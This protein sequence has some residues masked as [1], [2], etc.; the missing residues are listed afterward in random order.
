MSAA[1]FL[2]QIA[3]L[4]AFTCLVHALKPRVGKAPL[5]ML[6]GLYEAFLF[7]STKTKDPL[8][9][10][11]FFVEPR[12]IYL[13]FLGTLMST[14]VLVY[15]LEGTREARRVIIGIAVLYLTHG[16]LD[17][18]LDHH[19]ANPPPGRPVQTGADVFW[20]STH[21]RIASLTAMVCD[22][23]V[24]IIVYQFL[25][26]RAPRLPLAVPLFLGI[27]AAM[28]T[29]AA[30][31]KLVRH[32]SLS[33]SIF[34]VGAKVQAGMA[35]GLPAALYFAY[36]VRQEPGAVRRGIMHRGAFDIVDVREQMRELQLALEHQRARLDLVQQVFRRYVSPDVVDAIL[37]DPARLQLGGEEREVTI[38]FAD[39]R[40]YST[41]S[42]AMAPTEII[43]LL[44]AY[45][46]RVGDVIMAEGGMINEFEGDAVLAV[47]GAPIDL[48]DHPEKAVRAALGMFEVVEGLNEDWARDGTLAKWQASGVDGLAIR[49]GIHTGPVVVGNIGSEARTKYAV[50]GDTVNTASRIEGLNKT[51]RTSLLISAT[52]R[53]RLTDP[54]LL[55]AFEDR[56][57]QAV[58]GRIE[59]VR[60]HALASEGSPP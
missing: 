35:A 8:V 25:V 58:K 37:A 55:E 29:D 26:N 27:L 36:R 60:V 53:A 16:V 39:I 4:S 14:T 6:F 43:D 17:V 40:G 20:Y 34:F 46:G 10:E 5:Y 31:F 1:F 33:W 23:V 13:M 56:G 50:I 52:T 54:A 3:A 32:G 11:L 47:F 49:V 59:P 44:N 9:T 48:P 7:F 28:V 30:V 12:G 24:T 41:L 51:L 57:P 42:E 22:L 19:A 18:V 15:V 45:F 2:C 21:A 38:L